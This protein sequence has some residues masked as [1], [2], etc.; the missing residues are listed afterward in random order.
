M[1]RDI[2]ASGRCPLS[3]M[4]WP[5][6]CASLDGQCQLGIAGTFP[7][8]RFSP[9]PFPPRPAGERGSQP[10]PTHRRGALEAPPPLWSYRLAAPPALAARRGISPGR[11]AGP[12]S[13]WVFWEI[14]VG[15]TSSFGQFVFCPG[16]CL[17]PSD[18]SPRA[19]ETPV[20]F[21]VAKR[22]AGEGGAG[23]GCSAGEALF[24]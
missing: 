2:C 11:P 8:P 7:T 15:A 1:L 3:L 16:I 4:L 21:Q 13:W 20:D 9:P 6:T 5:C 14:A 24:A 17:A 23:C 10:P 18:P 12:R 22:G 19:W